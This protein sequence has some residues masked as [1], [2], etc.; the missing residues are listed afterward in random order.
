MSVQ[1]LLCVEAKF[2]FK[3]NFWRGMTRA[4]ARW[5]ET[6]NLYFGVSIVQYIGFNA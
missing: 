1:G 4:D 5:F 2:V 3:D 6:P